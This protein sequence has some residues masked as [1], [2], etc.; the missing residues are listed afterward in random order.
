M[1]LWG[2]LPPWSVLAIIGLVGL[3]ILLFI[4][5]Y[6]PWSWFDGVTHEIG[7]ALIAASVLGFTIDRWL[8][9]ELRTDAFKAA[10]G[11]VLQPEFRAEVSRIVGYSHICKKHLLLVDLHLDQKGGTV[12]VMSSIERV[13]ENKSSYVGNIKNYVHID[14]WGFPSGKS[15]ILECS[16]KVGDQP[17]SLGGEPCS[18][19]RQA[20]AP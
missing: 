7:I 8:K 17:A 10:L 12:R 5:N 19:S 15:E 11:H 20:L 14:E 1:S 9:A 18:P 16:L 3:L 2:K 13:I 4:P 6:W